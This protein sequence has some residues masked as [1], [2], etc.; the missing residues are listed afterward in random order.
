M[1][2]IAILF[3]LAALTLSATERLYLKDGSW[4]VVREYEVQK[5]RVRYYSTERS[6][7]EEIPLELVDLEKTRKDVADTK[8][9]LENDDKEEAEERAAAKAARKLASSVPNDNGAYYIR[10][11][12]I[13]PIKV[14]ES[15]FVTDKKRSILKVISPIPIVPGKGT[16]EIDGEHA[17]L[18]L[19]EKRPEFFFRINAYERYEIIRLKP[20]KKMSRIA[21]N[22][23][24]LTIQKENM[25]EETMDTVEAFK[26]QEE[27]NLYRVWPQKELEPG[28][29]AIVQY[30]EGK[31]NPQLWDFRVQ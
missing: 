3:A 1:P 13:E 2:R 17:S 21:M 22:V 4:H 23:S 20:S 29:Y 7:W 24:I 8:A 27:D 28:E 18:I 5:D 31:L 11:E 10:G 9:R 25:V 6:D 16:V 30:T 15:K 12:K 26:K 19:Q 14:A